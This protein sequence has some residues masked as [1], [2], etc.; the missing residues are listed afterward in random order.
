MLAA[1]L[2]EEPEPLS[3]R[4]PGVP[5]DLEAVVFR[6]LAKAPERRFP[7]VDTLDRAL[8]ATGKGFPVE[9]D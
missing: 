4:R 2:Y 5:A 7:D 8:A 9:C 3:A 1:H 6:C